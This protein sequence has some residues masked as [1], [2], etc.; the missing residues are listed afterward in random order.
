ML[1]FLDIE[2]ELNLEKE[3]ARGWGDGSVCKVLLG[4]HKNLGSD[5]QDP[6]KPGMAVCAWN[7][8]SGRVETSPPGITAGFRSRKHCLKEYGKE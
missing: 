7:P 4:K 2:I 3:G 6:W 1:L 5:S 8:I